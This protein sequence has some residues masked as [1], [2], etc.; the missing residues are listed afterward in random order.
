MKQIQKLGNWRQLLSRA[1]GWLHCALIYALFYGT[2][3]RFLEGDSALPGR[4]WWGLLSILPLA[5]ADMG[6]QVCGKLVLYLPWSLACCGLAWLLLG[7]PAAAVPVA[8]VC[9]FRGKNRL[10]EEPVESMMDRPSPPLTALALA[11]FFYSALDGSPLLQKL[12]LI[13]AALYLLLCAAYR[14]IQRLDHYLELNRGMAGLPARRIARTTGLALAGMLVLAAGLLLPALTLEDSYLRIDPSP[15]ERTSAVRLEEITPASGGMEVNMAEALQQE[16]GEPPKMNPVVQFILGAVLCVIGGGFGVYLLYLV[17]RNFRGA[18]EGRRGHAGHCAGPL[19]RGTVLR[20]EGRRGL[21]QRGAHPR[22]GHPPGKRPCR[23]W[24]RP[25]LPGAEGRHLRRGQGAGRPLRGLAPERLGGG[26]F[27][28]LGRG[29]AGRL[30]RA[31][32]LPLGL[33]RQHGYPP[34]GGGCHRHRP[35]AGVH[36]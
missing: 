1:M 9:F 17:I 32:P 14:G 13:W 2:A 28:P 24:H 26:G 35:R 10:S 29:P 31:A 15:P 25:L 21:P 22:G 3:Y 6:T 33:R 4:M 5:A 12:S 27:V 36:L 11:P 30:F 18:G 16:F 7:H 8:L 23:L 20:G 34:G 19:C